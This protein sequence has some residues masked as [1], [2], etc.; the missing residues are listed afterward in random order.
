MTLR[1]RTL[2]ADDY[3]GKSYGPLRGFYALTQCPSRDW[4][5]LRLQR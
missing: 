4:Q 1:L 3:S 2:G 5:P